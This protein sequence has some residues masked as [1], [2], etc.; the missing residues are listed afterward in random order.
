MTSL[1][2]LKSLVPTLYSPSHPSHS[3]IPHYLITV[4][5]SNGCE[6][7]DFMLTC[8]CFAF[9]FILDPGEGPV[10]LMIASLDNIV[11]T[12]LNG[13]SVQILKF[14]DPNGTHSLDF[15]H[16]E[17]SVCWVTSSRSSGQLWCAKMRKPNGFSKEREIK[18][19]QSFPSKTEFFS[20]IMF[21]LL[22]SFFYPIFY[23]NFK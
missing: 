15:N 17:E 21:H 12:T 5:A 2:L 8:H 10:A 11:I 6:M 3:S 13:S 23:S 1:F 22:I 19:L 9:T 16:N 4:N 14:L 20:C 7:P 18:S